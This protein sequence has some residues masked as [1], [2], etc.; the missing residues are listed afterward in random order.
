MLFLPCLHILQPSE[1]LDDSKFSHFALWE[2][3]NLFQMVYSHFTST[4]SFRRNMIIWVGEGM[5]LCRGGTV[6][7]HELM[8]TVHS[9]FTSTGSFRRNLSVAI[10]QD[11]N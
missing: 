2:Y 1:P 3:K 6:K 8:S 10:D 9:R 11:V 7:R 5:N 4:D